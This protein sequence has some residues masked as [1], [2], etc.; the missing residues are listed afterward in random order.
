M[1]RAFM[2]QQGISIKSGSCIGS[3]TEAQALN[4]RMWV[5]RKF[6]AI[7]KPQTGATACQMSI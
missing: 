7:L 1:S 6:P 4:K 2:L 5:D 3:A